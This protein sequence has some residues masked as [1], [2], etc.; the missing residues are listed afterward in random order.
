[1]VDDKNVT[2][3]SSELLIVSF[4]MHGFNQ[5]HQTIRDLIIDSKPDIFLLQ[6]HWLTPENLCKFDENFPSY[7]C[8]GSS[9]M[10]SRLE[11]GVLRGR[12]FGG[13]AVLVNR[14][15]QNCIKIVCTAERYTII[16]IGDLLVVDVY[17]PCV[18]VV[19]RFCIC[20]DIINNLLIWMSKYPD[21]KLILGGDFN[22]DLEDENNTITALLK[23]FIR[24]N[25]L[26]RCDDNR[27]NRQ[28]TYFNEA[29]NCGS[30]IDYFLASANV[31]TSQF[32]VLDP[33]FNLSDHFPIA[34]K[35]ACA[36]NTDVSDNSCN[37]VT[38]FTIN[39]LRWDYA[40]LDL[41]KD[42]TGAYLQ[43]V[44]CELDAIDLVADDLIACQE[45]ERVYNLIVQILSNCADSTIPNIKQNFFK[46]W[47]DQELTTL[48]QQ[49]IASCKIWKASGKPRSGPIFQTYRKDKST[50]K[51]AIRS[52][53]RATKETYT[54][55]LHEALMQKEGNS[56]WKC[57]RS[58]F[59]SSNQ[60]VQH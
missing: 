60:K 34:V 3:T 33:N 13:T 21:R 18:G 42:L 20:E 43:N 38:E 59:G 2:S 23:Q 10:G 39:Q 5:G 8:V 48:K 50:Y 30:C 26:K 36:T 46:F 25:C 45:I 44:I 16:I 1:M 14:R 27:I 22:T 53:Q 55:D 17:F 11:T 56:F 47:W 6:E 24:D 31:A 54:N 41:Y 9:A 4:N 49:S 35:C 12:P 52:R 37:N 51:A 29:L 19:D 58:K 15:F 40:H 7:I 28:F 32:S 57:W